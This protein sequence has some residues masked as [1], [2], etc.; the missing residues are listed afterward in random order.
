MKRFFIALLMV[1]LF[2]TPGF[3]VDPEEQNAGFLNFATPTVTIR[4]DAIHYIFREAPASNT[5]WLAS[6]TNCTYTVLPR[7]CTAFEINAFGA[8]IIMG[9]PEDLSTGNLYVGHKIASGTAYEWKDLDA[10]QRTVYFGLKS[11]G[12]GN[13]TATFSGW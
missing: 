3:C 8:D 12:A 4:T 1:V 9:H 7:N 10:E 13:A 5:T 6:H 2:I 11:N